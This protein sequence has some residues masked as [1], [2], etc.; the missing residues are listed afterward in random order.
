ML[1]LAQPPRKDEPSFD[2]WMYRLW[3]R[4]A[5]TAGL[6]WSLIDKTG[7][8]LSDIPDRQYKD[9]QY[10]PTPPVMVWSDSG[11]DKDDGLIGFVG[12]G[13]NT[14]VTPRYIGN[15][16]NLDVA[17]GNLDASQQAQ[18]DS[19]F[20]SW[21]GV[22]NYYSIA[23]NALTLLRGGTGFIQGKRI[24]WVAPQTTTT[25]TAYSCHWIYID[26]TGTLG[27]ATTLSDA[28]YANN[29]LLFE[30]HYDGTNYEVVV[31]NHPVSFDTDSQRYLHKNVGTIISPTL[32]SQVVGA[33]LTKITSGGGGAVT[34]RQLKMVG[35]AS[36]NDHGLETVIPDSAGVAITWSFYY[37][38][39]LGRWVEYTLG[40]GQTFPMVWNNA[41]TITALNTS[42]VNS[43]AV[44]RCY[45]IKAEP[46]SNLPTYIGVIDTTAYSNLG[47][48]TAAITADAV[49]YAT[50]TLFGLEPAQLGLATLNNNVA[51]GTIDSVV[52]AKDTLR[53]A[54]SSGGTNSAAL[55][56]TNTS[57][58]G[59]NLSAADTTVQ[60]ALDTLD[61]IRV[62]SIPGMDGEDGESGF[63]Y[64]QAQAVASGSGLT[65]P[66]VLTRVSF[67]M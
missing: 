54:T 50:G 57:G 67:R 15:S 60:A 34:D 63:I 24:S 30:V 66:Q 55:V 47:T 3:K 12:S 16:S 18:L 49:A 35:A 14:T 59:N 33:N 42:G 10:I 25:F 46:N 56:T 4:I 29:I 38:D 51:G 26:A 58:F 19:G 21:T 44:I 7:A 31:E 43:H 23:A 17:L 8:K 62:N 27:M 41:G 6:A 52:I 28:L 48:A 45:A 39:A 5:S 65:H 37:T 2:D 61:H 13:G 40:A 22:G 20:E 64:L 53:S 32:G 36:V 9:L 1:P 11:D